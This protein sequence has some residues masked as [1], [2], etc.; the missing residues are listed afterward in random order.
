[1]TSKKSQ[2]HHHHSVVKKPEISKHERGT[3]ITRFCI[4]EHV[5][6]VIIF[7]VMMNLATAIFVISAGVIGYNNLVNTLSPS[8]YDFY[9]K[10]IAENLKKNEQSLAEIDQ[11][12][13]AMSRDIKELAISVED[14]K[15]KR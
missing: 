11:E 8:N 4:A 7:T 14:F 13:D 3:L 2:H 10:Q 5:H 12:V 1:M 9:R 6:K 15:K